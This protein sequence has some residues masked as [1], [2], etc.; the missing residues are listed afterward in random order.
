VGLQHV[1]N[2]NSEDS[3]RLVSTAVLRHP[4]IAVSGSSCDNHVTHNVSCAR[5][6]DACFR[7][8]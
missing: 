5:G 8:R 1:V 2:Q 7:F 6:Q 3:A 4:A